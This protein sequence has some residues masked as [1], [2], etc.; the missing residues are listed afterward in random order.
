MSK[1]G[2]IIT[3]VIIFVLFA[4]VLI[5]LGMQLFNG[6]AKKIGRTKFRQYVEN[7]QYLDSEGKANVD[8]NGNIV[9]VIDKNL[10]LEGYIVDANGKI[11][12]EEGNPS[13][14]V[15]WKVATSAYE[16]TGY[17][18]NEKGAYVKAYYCYGPFANSAESWNEPYS[19]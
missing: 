9:S 7:A 15:I 4:A 8:E 18:K 1:K 11:T 13:F 2:R 10:I 17:T 3:S 14:I 16:Y 19:T 6:G 12:A 5:V